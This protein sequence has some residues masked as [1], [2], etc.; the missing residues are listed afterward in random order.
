MVVLNEPG[1]RELA[2]EVLPLADM[3]RILDEEF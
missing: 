3:V 1:G 2:L